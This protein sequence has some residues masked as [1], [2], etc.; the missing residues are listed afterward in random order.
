M[1]FRYSRFFRADKQMTHPRHALVDAIQR[2][3]FDTVGEVIDCFRQIF[4]FSAGQNNPSFTSINDKYSQGIQ[5]MHEN[6]VAHR[7]LSFVLGKS[8]QRPTTASLSTPS[9]PHAGHDTKS[10]ILDSLV[11]TIHP[12]RFDARCARL[13]KGHLHRPGQALDPGRALRQIARPGALMPFL[14][15]PSRSRI[16]GFNGG[17]EI[18]RPQWSHLLIRVRLENFVAGAVL[19]RNEGRLFRVTAQRALQMEKPLSTSSA[20]A[21]N[22]LP[23]RNME[24]DASDGH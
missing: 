19:Q 20:W 14:R 8:D 6:F 9:E 4:E 15:M 10:S 18:K 17:S 22:F 2:T 11:V 13:S 23:K 3:K 7:L 24:T 1:P 16:C 12:T 5:F 21:L